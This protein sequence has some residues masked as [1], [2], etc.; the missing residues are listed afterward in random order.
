MA[1]AGRSSSRPALGSGRSAQTRP[2]RPVLTVLVNAWLGAKAPRSQDEYAR[3]WQTFCA[4]WRS[5]GRPAGQE[6]RAGPTEA[7]AYRD[8]LVAQHQQASTVS[9]RLA[10]MSSLWTY[11]G[12]ELLARRGQ[13]LGNPWLQR[14]IA[15]PK[16]RDRLAERI[17]TREGMEALLRA[18]ARIGPMHFAACALLYDTGLRASEAVGLTWEH[19]YDAARGAALNVYGKGGKTRHVL[20]SRRA[21]D[22]LRRRRRGPYLLHD[23]AGEPISRFDLR[24]IVKRAGAAAGLPGRLTTHWTRHSFI[25]HAAEAGTPLPTLQRAAGHANIETTMRYVHV[26]DVVEPAH[27][28]DSER[29]DRGGRRRPR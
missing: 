18:A 7:A 2:E 11:V 27:W 26:R 19:V 9:R 12:R 4:W 10:A 21:F 20:L 13:L 16:Q 3:D 29:W 17:L 6:L 8:W 5:T 1:G 15:R 25:T 24:K 22:A 23:L 14:Y 28:G